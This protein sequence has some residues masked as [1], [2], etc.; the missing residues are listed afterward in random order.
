MKHRFETEKGHSFYRNFI[1]SLVFFAAII[2]IFLSSVTMLS[3]RTRD[4][5]LETLTNAL[6]QNI[7]RCYALEGSY[8]PSVSYLV[9]KYGLL[10]DEERFYIDYHVVGSN[11]MPDVSIIDKEAE[12]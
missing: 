11:I 8:P 7:T 6:N 9:E 1:L 2:G 3:N 4:Q 12:R 10:Y 5:E